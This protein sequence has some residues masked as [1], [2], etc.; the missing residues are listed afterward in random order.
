MVSSSLSSTAAS[1]FKSAWNQQVAE[2]L[3]HLDIFGINLFRF[4]KFADRAAV[5]LLAFIRQGQVGMHVDVS[6]LQNERLLVLL[7]RSIHVFFVIQK[8]SQIVVDILVIWFQSQRF[9]KFPLRCVKPAHA[10]Q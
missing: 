7:D 1:A 6:G 4:S 8:I 10:Y 9:A 3:A 2:V 5:F